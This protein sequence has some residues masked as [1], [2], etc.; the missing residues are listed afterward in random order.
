MDGYRR[1]CKICTGRSGAG[2]KWRFSEVH[3]GYYQEK[4]EGEG[5]KEGAEMEREARM[6]GYLARVSLSM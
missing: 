3:F 5:G 4:G 1:V 6:S 2:K